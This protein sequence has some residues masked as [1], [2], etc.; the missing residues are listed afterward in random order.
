[1]KSDLPP[2]LIDNLRRLNPW[3]EGEAMPVQPV[4][5]RHLVA[6]M[7]R[8]L[9]A[10][11][12]TVVGVRGPRQ[13]GK[14]TAQFQIIQDLLAE[15]VDP[16]RILRVQFDDLPTLGKLQ[17]P[18]LR[19]SDWFERRVTPGRFNTQAQGGEPAYLFF[20]EIQNL[21]RWDVQLKSL[22][23]N[24][25]VK[26][27]VIGSPALRI[28]LGR[29][30]LAGRI[31][32]IEAGVLSLTEIGAL[33]ELET[34][35]PFLRDNGL[36]DLLEKGFWADLREYG[37]NTSASA[38]RHSLISPSAAGIPPC[39]ATRTWSSPYWRIIST[40]QSSRGSFNMT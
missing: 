22:V 5:R 32:T 34:P 12:A 30:S 14:T 25:S 31:N 9:D 38:K 8:R 28:E 6:Q 33:R 10:G 15:G 40:R 18:I 29:D 3:W 37:S 11:V 1:M 20:D 21:D 27:V 13:I 35:A 7:R 26:V 23:D 2:G 16:R 24:A 36:S 17:E 4:T 39:T 19:I